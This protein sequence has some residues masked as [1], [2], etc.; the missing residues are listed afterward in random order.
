ME[1]GPRTVRLLFTDEGKKQ[2][3]QI[4]PLIGESSSS[5]VEM[6]YEASDYYL[7]KVNEQT[8]IQL[9]RELVSAVIVRE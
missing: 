4:S 3:A 8:T 7:I 9:K 6:L 2:I 5:R 1:V